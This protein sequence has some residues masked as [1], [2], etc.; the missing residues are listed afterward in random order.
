MKRVSVILPVYNEAGSL[1]TLLTVLNSNYPDYEIIVVNDGSEDQTSAVCAQFDAQ[2]I[3][4]PYNMGNGAAVKTGM[5]HASGD[6]FVTMDADGQ[7]DPADIKNLL[8]YI[9]EY[10]MV[11]GARSFSGQATPQRALGN[12][13]YNTFASY[14]AKFRIKDLTSGFRA[15][16]RNVALEQLHLFPN[17]YSYP[18]TLTLAVLRSGYSLIYTPIRVNQRANGKSGI[19]LVKDGSR[20]LMIIIKV[21]TLY[22]PLRVFLPVSGMMFFLGVI[23]YAYTYFVGGRFTN[24][25]AVLFMSGVIIFM[26]GII[27]EQICQMRYERFNSEN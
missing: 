23:N 7:H 25:S 24:M 19:H 10:D 17:T 11:V 22:S 5:R 21:C 1:P 9:S 27:S 2:L 12:W 15:V 13:I 4:H 8:S 6:I 16:R 20:F 18:T 14:V 3:E 26:M